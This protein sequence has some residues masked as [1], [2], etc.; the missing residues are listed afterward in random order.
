MLRQ[1]P[2]L[3]PR[4]QLTKEG[5]FWF[6]G[7]A[8]THFYGERA[9]LLARAH[10]CAK[11]PEAPAVARHGMTQRAHW[12]GPETLGGFDRSKD[13][14]DSPKGYS[15][16]TAVPRPHTGELRW[17]QSLRRAAKA[18]SDDRFPIIFGAPDPKAQCAPRAPTAGP[19][20]KAWPTGLPSARLQTKPQGGPRPNTASTPVPS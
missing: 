14:A 18:S 20:S 11:H 16:S 8:P 6:R 13:P 1:D 4:G 2:E 10:W 5:L 9:A 12:Q 17:T 7:L 15:G 3:R 19:C